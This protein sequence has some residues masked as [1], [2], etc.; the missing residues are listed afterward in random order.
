MLVDLLARDDTT[1]EHAALAVARDFRPELDVEACLAEL[2]AMAEPLV[3]R[4]TSASDPETQADALAARLS[5]D[6][7]F[8]GNDDHYYDPDN[9]FLDR[10]IARRRGIPLTLSIVWLSVGRAAH[11]QVEG[12]GFPGHFLVRV[13]GSDGV[14][15]DPFNGG[16]VLTLGDLRTLAHRFLGHPEKL[17]P[18]HLATV[19]V[20]AMTIRLLTN[21][22][23]CHERRGDRRSSL[24]CSD[25]LFDVTGAPEHRRDRG[26]HALALGA[27]RAA[28]E[29]LE[30]YLAVR[31]TARDVPLVRDAIRRAHARFDRELS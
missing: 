15:V 21:L 27:H 13:G 6:L 7:G 3:H 25:R 10:V 2:R 17:A 18:E 28:V 11:M 16:R 29:D 4:Q 19:D 31:P 22:K 5:A 9:S 20:R 1:V 23:H 24:L 8:A 14:I 12:I 30:A 26:L